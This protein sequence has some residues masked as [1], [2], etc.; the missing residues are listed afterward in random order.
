MKMEAEKSLWN[1]AQTM[2]QSLC[3]SGVISITRDISCL[4]CGQTG[5]MDIHSADEVVDEKHLFRHIGHNPFSGDLHYQCPACGIVLL[6]D[7]ALALG[8]KPI[9]ARP[10]QFAADKPAREKGA[11]TGLIGKLLAMVFPENSEDFHYEAYFSS[12]K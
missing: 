6:V 4:H 5:I 12:K 10:R 3:D 8:E 7:P 11:E 2:G 9:K 1:P